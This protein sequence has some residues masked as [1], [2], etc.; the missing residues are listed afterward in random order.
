MESHSDTTDQDKVN[1]ASGKKAQQ[2]FERRFH[3]LSE[4]SKP[5]REAAERSGATSPDVSG[6]KFEPASPPPSFVSARSMILMIQIMR[7]PTYVASFGQLR[8]H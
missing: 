4:E 3:H 8:K 5:S 7:P 6:E 2:F 1:L